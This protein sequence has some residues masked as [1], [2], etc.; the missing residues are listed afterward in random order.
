MVMSEKFS[1]PAFEPIPANSITNL[2]THGYTQAGAVPT[3]AANHNK[4]SR[5]IALSFL[6][7]PLIFAGPTDPV[8]PGEG[9]FTFHLWFGF[10]CSKLL[11]PSACGPWRADA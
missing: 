11:P 1:N 2:A 9:L 5:V 4:M 7:G 6:P 8:R 3:R 10:T